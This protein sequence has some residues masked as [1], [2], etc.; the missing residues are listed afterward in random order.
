MAKAKR[1]VGEDLKLVD[2]VIEVLDARL[3]RSSG[4]QVLSEL[5]GS[6]PT[7]IALNKADL[8]E[9][10]ACEPLCQDLLRQDGRQ[11]GRYAGPTVDT[12]CS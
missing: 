4:N 7:V 10:L 8:S 1:I 2:V 5:I 6:K 11:T 3:P 12:R 9:I